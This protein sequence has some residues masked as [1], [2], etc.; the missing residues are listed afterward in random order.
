LTP[1]VNLCI[2]TNLFESAATCIIVTTRS[3]SNLLHNNMAQQPDDQV[4]V[5]QARVLELETAAAAAAAAA[6]PPG[7][8]PPAPPVFTL[9]PALANT[10]AAC[11]DLTS[12]SGAKH[13]KGAIEPLSSTPFNFGDPADLQVFLDMVLKRSQVCGWNPIL[14]VPVTNANGATTA[15]HNILEE[16]GVLSVDT[17]SAHV[18]TCCGLQTKQAQD[19]FML[20]QCLQASLSIKFLKIITA[21]LGDCHLP[22]ISTV[23]GPIPCGPLLLK[24]IIAKAHVDS[25]AMVMCI[26]DSICDL[27]GKMVDLGSNIQFSNLHV[28]TQVKALSARGEKSNDLLNNLFKGCKAADDSE[29]QDFIRRKLNE[30][31][32][33]GNIDVNN[34]MADAEAKFR[35]RVLNK[36]WSAPTK[37]QGQILALTPA[38]IE[39]LKTKSKKQLIAASA[40]ELDKPPKDKRNHSKTSEWAWKNIM[41]KPGEPTTKDFKGK[42]CHLGCKHHLNRWVCHETEDCS[43]NPANIAAASTSAAAAAEDGEKKAGSRRLKKAKLAA[44]L[45][46]EDEESQGDDHDSVPI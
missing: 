28:K 34:L 32:E 25:R 15:T 41:P 23:N 14:A 10:A 20:C 45:L 39:Q 6:V 37:E 7:G 31:E 26:Q 27:D 4:Q 19:S 21:E 9:A 30:H 18:R 16:H 11:V 44:A 36:E 22:A 8:A 43:L 35:T 29:F 46:E 40:N 5:L 1:Q 17:I 2:R 33:G 12:P 3:H 38:Q 42:H 13:F 24:I